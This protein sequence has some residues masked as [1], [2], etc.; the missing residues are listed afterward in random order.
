VRVR[1]PKRLEEATA[2]HLGKGKPRQVFL[3]RSLGTKDLREANIRA[4]PVLMEFDCVIA[5]AESIAAE[6]PLRTSLQKGEVE[7]IAEYFY[8]FQL[9]AD[10]EDRRAGGSEALFQDVARQLDQAGIAHE[11]PFH[12]GNVPEYGLSDREMFKRL[13]TTAIVLP[14]ARAG[15]A[16]GDFSFLRWEID[17]LL[18]VFRINLDPKSASYRELGTAILRAYVRSI[19]DVAK[20]NEGQVVDTPELIEPA[21]PVAASASTLNASFE[22]WTKA[23]SRPKNTLREFG[24]AVARFCELHGDVEI[25]CITRRHV[26]AFREA[27]QQM[28]LRRS[29]PLRTASLPELVE[30]SKKHLGEAKASAETVNKLLGAVGAI[31]QWGRDNGL[32][33]DDVQWSNPFSK[34]SLPARRST[35]EPWETEELQTLFGSPIFTSGERPQ[36]GGADAAFWLPLLGLFTGARLNELA[37]LTVEDLKVDDATG[38]HFLNIRE[39]AEQGRRLKTAGSARVIPVHPEL[40][41]IGL[42]RFADEIRACSGG[43]GRLFPLLTPGPQGGFGEAWSKWFGRF[44]RGLGI[45]NK[46]SVFHSFRHGFKDALRRAAVSEDVNDALTGHASASIGRSYG[47]KDMVRRFGMGTLADAVSKVA[48]PGFDLGALQWSGRQQKSASHALAI[49]PLVT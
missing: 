21:D 12:I 16:R 29:G 5:Q 47:A 8:A 20:R 2:Q 1:V 34:M 35:R 14:V 27:L 4:K 25:T 22:G 31:A 48:Y 40:V 37:P 19:E 24:Y 42:L 6:R 46:A 9:E 3:Q 28:P 30:W 7:K 36:A 11:G 23:A 26:L 45:T 33:P 15:L 43:E 17:E 38:T 39:V 49:V 13:E 44:K 32:I 10:D 18:K 41:R